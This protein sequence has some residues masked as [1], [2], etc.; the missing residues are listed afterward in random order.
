METAIC[1]SVC[2]SIFIYITCPTLTKMH[3]IYQP[4]CRAHHCY[5]FKYICIN[6]SMYL[7]IYVSMYLCIHVPMYPCTYVSMYLCII[8]STHPCIYITRYPCTYVP[9]YLCMYASPYQCSNVPMHLRIYVSMYLCIYVLM[10]L[11]TNVSTMHQCINYAPM[12]QRIYQLCA[13]P[14]ARDA[15]RHRSTP[16]R[17]RT[18]HACWPCACMMLRECVGARE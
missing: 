12:Y 14:P 4:I 16:R 17:A 7:R 9:M 11:C 15:C 10:K 13:P 1:L 2:L 8:V 5:V 6:V 18:T 3:N